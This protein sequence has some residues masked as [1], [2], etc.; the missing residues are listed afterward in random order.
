MFEILEHLL[1]VVFVSDCA[2]PPMVFRALKK[3]ADMHSARSDSSSDSDDTVE[4]RRVIQ[5]DRTEATTCNNMPI[6][7]S[8]TEGKIN[9]LIVTV[10]GQTGN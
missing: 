5:G 1:K 2:Y 8:V 9:C 4:E 6:Q 10:I 3:I 7:Q